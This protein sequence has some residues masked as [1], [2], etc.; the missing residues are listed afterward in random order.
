MQSRLLSMITRNM[1]FFAVVSAAALRSPGADAVVDFDKGTGTMHALHDT[2]QGPLDGAKW[3]G[4]GSSRNPA[5]AK[6]FTPRAEVASAG[7][8][9]TGVGW[10]EAFLNGRKI[11]DKVLD[12]IPTQYDRRVLYS[13]YDVTDMLKDGENELGL[14]LGNGLYNV[15][16]KCEWSFDRAP[17]RADPAGIAALEVR[18]VDGMVERIVTDA[19]WRVAPSPVLFNAFREGEVV[20]AEARMDGSPRNATVVAG[21]AGRLELETAPAAKVVRDVPVEKVESLPDGSTVYRMAENMAGWARIR[22]AGLKK[23]DVVTIR[24]DERHPCES[25]R[26]ID[27]F[28]R[29]LPSTNS[30]PELAAD[31]AGFQVDRFVSAGGA[32]EFYEPRFTWNG[33]RYVTVRGAKPAAGDVVG[34]F[35]RTS[36][37][38]TGSFEC[39]D[40]GFMKIMDATARA[41]ESNFTDGFPT[42]CP[43]REKNGWLGDA[44]LAIRYAALEWGSDENTLAYRNWIRTIADLQSED[45]RI[46]SIAP[47]SL[48]FHFDG[49]SCAAG[50]AWGA[51]LTTIPTTLHRYR[52]DRAILSEA[53]PAM[54]KYVEKLLS[55]R[56][57]R[58]LFVAGLGD[59]C[60]VSWEWS[61]DRDFRTSLALVCS[62]CAYASVTETAD[63]AQVLGL[64]DDAERFRAE[65]ERIRR[66]FNAGLYHGDGRYDKKSSPTAQATALEL[67]LVEESEIPAVRRR[68]VEAVHEMDDKIDFGII[69]SR[70]VFRQL[71][72]AGE[73]DLAWKL[74]TRPDYPSYLNM[75]SQDVNTLM[76]TFNGKSSRNHIMFGDV[77][78]WAYEYLAGIRVGEGH[79]RFG[80][81]ITVKPFVP[82]ALGHVKASVELPEGR[83]TVEWT[84]KDGKFSLSLDIPNGVTATVVMP[85]GRVLSGHAR[86][87]EW[88]CDL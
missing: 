54:R 85:D 33:F 17:W 9:V 88:T 86:H 39:D 79:A 69:G 77:G 51:A 40:A 84:K 19:S 8:A 83:V 70:T 25:P 76:E 22:F 52:K 4:D 34:R 71:C 49:R 24:Y 31:T 14:L 63:A 18:Y 81:A 72:E 75:V 12:P 53:Y 80:S 47:S 66:D 46:S 1:C 7:L 20:L 61:K 37:R 2:G 44:A 42:D 41:Y 21:P 5:F 43:H 23:G 35:V 28:C 16:E 48:L 27:R 82:Q 3:I 74:I 26:Q 60:A 11:G 38:K 78:A 50:P 32:E 56:N 29:S 36:F 45:G 13:T 73:V 10:Y 65:A 55:E 30:C 15:Q 57:G 87:Q 64:E 59:W 68:L 6:R 67:G 62:A 58:G